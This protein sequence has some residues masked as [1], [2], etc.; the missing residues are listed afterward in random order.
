MPDVGE[1]GKCTQ[2]G[3]GNVARSSHARQRAGSSSNRE[4]VIFGLGYPPSKYRLKR[5]ETHVH[6]NTALFLTAKTQRQ[7]K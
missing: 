3:G 4:T 6:T 2:N 1:H 5:N 7:Q